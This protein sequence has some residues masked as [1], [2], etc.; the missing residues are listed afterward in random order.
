MYLPG[1]SWLLTHKQRQLP[2]SAITEIFIFVLETDGKRQANSKSQTHSLLICNNSPQ[3]G[4]DTFARDRCC[5]KMHNCSFYLHVQLLKPL[6]PALNVQ[7]QNSE[8]LIM[9]PCLKRRLSIRSHILKT[10]HKQVPEAGT[11]KILKR[12]CS[13]K[14]LWNY[15]RASVSRGDVHWRA[16]AFPFS[17]GLEWTSSKCPLLLHPKCTHLISSKQKWENSHGLCQD[18]RNCA[19]IVHICR[20]SNC[21]TNAFIPLI[22]MAS[23]HCLPL[24]SEMS[25][26]LQNLK[27][28]IFMSHSNFFLSSYPLIFCPVQ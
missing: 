7:M 19:R 17:S 25:Q 24:E 23:S 12:H 6:V 9:P 16:A 13:G 22:L 28:I 11:A 5:A 10:N 27:F 2:H 21:F 4:K 15:G 20:E 3:Q 1:S 18:L 14:I 8:V 26:A